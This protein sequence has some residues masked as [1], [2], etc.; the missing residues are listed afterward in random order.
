MELQI[1]DS[2]FDLLVKKLADHFHPTKIYLFGSRAKGAARPDSDYDLF[3]IVK[4][5]DKS[6]TQRMQEANRIL[7]GSGIIA[8]IFVYTEAEFDD[9]KD[10]LNSIAC[11][12]ASE[13]VELPI[14]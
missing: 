3:I 2:K 4:E 11:I 9:W 8:D 1:H 6:S 12:V 14:V 10:E 5:S 7:W 13:G